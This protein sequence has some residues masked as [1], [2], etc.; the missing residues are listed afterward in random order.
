MDKR[1]LLVGA[2]VV[3]GLGA[4]AFVA[5]RL[6]NRSL[7]IYTR[8][9]IADV[10][11]SDGNAA[12]VTVDLTISIENPNSN[13]T[14]AY[15]SKNAERLA[16][17]STQQVLSPYTQKDI[18]NKQESILPTLREKLLANMKKAGYNVSH[19]IIKLD[20]EDNE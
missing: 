19:I 11:L 7:T 18:E 5:L 14:H 17:Q 12:Q 13:D 9:E 10:E 4:S 8:L 15:V 1:S 6:M 16:R 2:A 20:T 3:L